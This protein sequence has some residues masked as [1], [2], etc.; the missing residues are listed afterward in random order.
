MMRCSRSSGDGGGGYSSLPPSRLPA[1]LPSVP[2][3]SFRFVSFPSQHRQTGSQSSS[4]RHGM[5]NFLTS[6]HVAC[7]VHP[8]ST[9]ACTRL[10]VANARIAA[11]TNV[12]ITNKQI[13]SS[14]L[15]PSNRFSLHEVR[16]TCFPIGIQEYSLRV[17]C[18]GSID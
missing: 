13:P 18:C 17:G 11:R 2:S 1:C 6:S 15:P 9:S 8:V 5:P 3:L 16:V 10:P 12:T 7:I 4:R 14:L